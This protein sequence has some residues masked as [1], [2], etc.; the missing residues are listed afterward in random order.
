MP[1]LTA[2]FLFHFDIDN[3]NHTAERQMTL[4]YGYRCDCS[5]KLYEVE[6]LKR[7]LTIVTV[8]Y[9]HDFRAGGPG[10]AAGFREK[11][12][13][14]GGS[15]LR[16]PLPS[17]HPASPCPGRQALMSGVTPDPAEAPACAKMR[18]LASTRHHLGRRNPATLEAD[19]RPPSTPP[20]ESV[21]S[22][23]P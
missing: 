11:G 17:P 4:N 2:V 16:R 9:I 14:P 5:L 18:P 15:L 21:R 19:P 20:G 13:R 12:I 8:I 3:C 22:S 10:F 6:Y 23:T 1:P 7:M